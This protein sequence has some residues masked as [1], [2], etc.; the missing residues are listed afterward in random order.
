MAEGGKRPPNSLRIT[1]PPDN[2][3][4]IIGD[5]IDLPS[6]GV[7]ETV[8]S[9]S[10]NKCGGSGPTEQRDQMISHFQT[11]TYS[12]VF[13]EHYQALPSKVWPFVVTVKSNPILP[14]QV[15]YDTLIA[16][17]AHT[18]NNDGIKR[19]DKLTYFAGTMRIYVSKYEWMSNLVE[20][21][22]S[23]LPN[24]LYTVSAT[25]QKVQFLVH[26]RQPDMC[27]EDRDLFELS[28]G[29]TI[30]YFIKS[31]KSGLPISIAAVEGMRHQREDVCTS[32]PRAFNCFSIHFTLKSFSEQGDY[33]FP[34]CNICQ[35]WGHWCQNY[36]N[37]TNAKCC[38][39]SCVERTSDCCPDPLKRHCANC[40]GPHAAFFKGCPEFKRYWAWFKNRGNNPSN[41]PARKSFYPGSSSPASASSAQ[42]TSLVNNPT[43]TNA[44]STP[45]SSYNQLVTI[46]LL[47]R[48]LEEACNNMLTIMQSR[49]TE[50]LVT[51]ERKVS[52]MLTRLSE[53]PITLS[54]FVKHPSSSVLKRPISIQDDEFILQRKMPIP[55]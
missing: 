43:F 28:F 14:K 7:D 54:S 22:N 48:R 5:S 21:A 38:H 10:P 19:V 18:L 35:Q 52:V 2:R 12:N 30:K 9:D 26:G 6:T 33:V 36:T 50:A 37:Q 41:S 27:N 44:N 42:V 53:L 25:S 39:C 40:Q 49:I 23:N 55:S 15:M 4:Q 24:N 17:W 32:R 51:F 16:P 3:R 20:F 31:R 46:E 34:R 45:V 29:C 47:E 1:V 11:K 8:I 13:S